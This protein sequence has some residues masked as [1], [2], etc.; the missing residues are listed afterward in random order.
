MNWYAAKLLADETGAD[1]T[2]R[3]ASEKAREDD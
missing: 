2:A 1:G 3:F